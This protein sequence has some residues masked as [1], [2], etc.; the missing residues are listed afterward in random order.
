MFFTYKHTRYAS[1]LG[2]ITQA[3]VNNLPPLLFIIF[4][5]DFGISLEKIGLLISINF[6]VQ[7]FVDLLAAKYVDRIGYKFASVA[8]HIFCAA[9]LLGLGIFP[10]IFPNAYMGIL[11]AIVI[12]AIGGG[13]I[14]VLVSPIVEALPGDEKESAMSLLHSF[15]CW[16]HVG[17]VILST[18]FFNM[19]GLKS[20]VYLPIMWSV[21]PI[22]NIF[23]FSKVP[24]RTLTE[25]GSSMSLRK[26]C[27]VKLFWLLFILMVCSGAS[28]QA[29][30]QWA[31]LFAE[32]GLKVSKNMGDLLGP[33]A[34]AI[35]MG[36]SRTIYGFW[37]SKMNLI[38]TIAASG[39]LCVI[40]YLLAVF[41][42]V[43]IIALLG[44]AMCGFAVGIMW[45]GVFS[46]SSKHYPQGGIGMFA[47]LALAGDVGCSAGPGLVGLVSNSSGNLKNGLLTAIV[48]PVLLILGIIVL[49]RVV[50]RKEG[51][52]ADG[53]LQ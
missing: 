39:F 50:E 51:G 20:W 31:S 25:E 8:A 1:Y 24:I 10:R 40:S 35:L 34:F 46:L 48:F 18:V 36:I 14:E 11:L 3:I 44:C 43:P 32:M 9:G 49:Y 16:G 6:G 30:S 41:S 2:Y 33:C 19:L 26:L 21:I 12:N 17:V 42:P 52:N 4:R 53:A 22:F 15:Y 47:I 28:E 5:N 37:G 27:K 13:L 45:P 29:M 23:L 38:K 7:I